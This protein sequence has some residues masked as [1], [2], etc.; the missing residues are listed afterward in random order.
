MTGSLLIASLR[1]QASLIA[2]HTIKAVEHS[3]GYL[4]VKLEALHL[5]L[6]WIA[7]DMDPTMNGAPPAEPDFIW[8]PHY[9]MGSIEPL[10]FKYPI[11]FRARAD[12][13]RPCKASAGERR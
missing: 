7:H 8:R 2:L 9:I 4:S 6:Y 1:R 3:A 5:Y 10:W 12:L 13:S 11:S